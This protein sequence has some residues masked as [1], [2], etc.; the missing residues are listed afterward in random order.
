[1]SKWWIATGVVIG[2]TWG[3]SYGL[4][5]TVL[6]AGMVAILG[7]GVSRNVQ[8]TRRGPQKAT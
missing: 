8:V 6:V 4:A 5:Y 2:V 7:D 3:S 1:M